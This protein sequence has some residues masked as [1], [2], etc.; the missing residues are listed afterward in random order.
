MANSELANTIAQA[1][2][3]SLEAYSGAMTTTELLAT[4]EA[5]EAVLEGMTDKVYDSI[6]TSLDDIPATASRGYGLV[7]LRED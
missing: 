7:V 6:T 5:D 3:E 1:V 2:Q 4:L